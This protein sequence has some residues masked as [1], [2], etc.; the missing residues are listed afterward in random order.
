M[1]NFALYVLAI[2]AL[3]GAASAQIPKANI[4]FG[5]S[6]LNSDLVPGQRDNLNGWNASLEGKLVPF[7]GIV[8]D[9]G[10][11]YGT[12]GV[13]ISNVPCTGSSCPTLQANENMYTVMFGPQVSASVGKL[14]PFAHALFGIGHVSGNASGFSNSDTSFAT[15]LGGGIDYKLIPLIA[16]R[17]Q[18]DYLHTKFFG[19]SQGD[20]RFSTGVV[21]R[22]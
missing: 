6:Y 17:F 13:P 22:F 3:A 16:W 2:T 5:Y 14:T 10:G 15:G 18:G 8:G 7:I 9:F 4:F 12:H 1:R 21:L 19:N 11:Y 20:F